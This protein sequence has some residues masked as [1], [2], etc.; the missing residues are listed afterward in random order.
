VASTTERTLKLL[1]ALTKE[2]QKSSS[3]RNS[4]KTIAK[5]TPKAYLEKV[6]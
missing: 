1:K 6:F 4:K 2:R 3:R 5:S